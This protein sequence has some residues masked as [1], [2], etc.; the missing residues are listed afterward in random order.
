[1]AAKI[2][3]INYK[4]DFILTMNSE[5]GWT[6]PFCIKFWT[7]APS[8]AYFAGW[9]G[10]TY[11]HCALDGEDPTKLHVQF[12]DHHL[13]IGDLKFQI[14]YHFTVEDFPNNTEDEVIN[15]AAVII[16]QDGTQM[17]VMLDLN[18][19]TAPEIEFNLPAYANEAQ[20][21]ANEEQRISNEAQRIANEEQRIANE[22]QRI[23]N[24]EQR[25]SAESI[26]IANEESRISEFA[27]LKHDAEIATA[28]A[29]AAAT[30]ANEKAALAAEKAALSQAAAELANAKATL[31]QQ[32][33]DYAQAQGDY[34]KAQGDYAK[35]Q[36][37]I[38][39]ADHERAESDHTRAENDHTAVEVYVD[40][41]GAFDIS[42]YHAT[43]GVLAKYVDLSAA[44]DGGD[45][46]PEAIRKGGMSVKFVQSSDNK[47][48]QYFL[49]KDDW[50]ASEA[51]W[52]KMNLEEELTELSGIVIGNRIINC[53][54]STNY[55][56]E[57]IANRK[58]I[59]S[60]K[61]QATTSVYMRVNEDGPNIGIGV[62]DS[63]D[64]LI[65]TP[66]VD[67]HFVRTNIDTIIQLADTTA[68][69][70]RVEVLED[71]MES[72]LQNTTEQIIEGIASVNYEFRF[73][74]HTTYVV[75]NLGENESSVFMRVTEDGPNIAIAAYLNGGES[76]EFTP[77]VEGYYIRL[78]NAT[79]IKVI[80]K[81]SLIKKVE[82]LEYLKTQEEKTESSLFRLQDETL[83]NNIIDIAAS[84]TNYPLKLYSGETYKFTNKGNSTVSVFLRITESGANIAVGVLA[85]NDS[86]LYTATEDTN[87]IRLNEPS[88]IEI[89][90]TNSILQRVGVCET[91][92]DSI[93]KDKVLTTASTSA[94]TFSFIINVGEIY[95][96]INDTEYDISVF[97]R[98][99]EDGANIDAFII[100]SGTYVNYNAQARSNFI[101]LYG[102]GGIASLKTIK[103]DAL[104]GE[105]ITNTESITKLLNADSKQWKYILSDVIC[106][107]DSVT[108]GHIVDV[109]RVKEP[110]L[111]WS[112]P[113]RLAEMNGWN[114]T[115]AGKSGSTAPWYWSNKFSNYNYANYQLAIIEY[116]INDF[117][118]VG[119]IST[120]VE[121]YSDYHDYANTYVGRMCSIIEGIKA[122][123]PDIIIILNISHRG[124]TNS[125]LTAFFS[126]Q[127]KY[128]LPYI[129]LRE[130]QYI[131]LEDRDYH[132]YGSD[133]I[134]V[135][136]L[137]FNAFGYIAKAKLVNYYLMQYFNS[138]ILA[139]NAKLFASVPNSN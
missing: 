97:F 119:D 46:I 67:G 111:S 19:E 96:L 123:N 80:D 114:I 65:F 117:E 5:A 109:P 23:S 82:D 21:I 90:N 95:R 108:E 4:S 50:S 138:N 125:V 51:D 2:F 133:G 26:R 137:H 76:V 120:D 34:A 55:E 85:A 93:R 11:I 20:R 72:V 69:Y 32:K 29:N 14:A 25:I 124:F 103:F 47:Y 49:T 17:Q 56:Y 36:G 91:R 94:E 70:Q 68:V 73:V 8:I 64:S 9:D 101:R 130:K 48:V 35:D 7:G 3:R 31:A 81:A 42:A 43:G 77:E 52:E 12:D 61:G 79:T 132:G 53:T 116:G 44:L 83:G 87:Y 37:N 45:N 122:Q 27:Q 115:N 62:I 107:G 112:Y 129:D 57:F 135:N 13:P 40:S 39:E 136:Y 113:T 121:P 24:E 128:S 6:I 58:Y 92:L 60:N 88:I 38:A 71:K 89:S 15:Q 139:L 1:M 118:N 16:D 41:L 33:A 78:S 102:N 105:V 74:A 127:S 99:T 63:G 84:S 86:V 59:I 104:E 110:V 22:E 98:E 134:T 54:A 100:A 106:I 131:D 30:L 28:D 66:S 18:G 10:T 75:S 126:I